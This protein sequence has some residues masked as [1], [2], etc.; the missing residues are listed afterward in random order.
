M[1]SEPTSILAFRNGS[2]G[3]TLAA[4]PALRA[5]RER[6]PQATLSVVVDSIGEDLLKPCPWIDHLIC[7]DKRG[8][9]RRIVA[10]LRL[11]RRLRSLKPSH[12]V[13]FKRFFRNGLLSYLSGARE[14]VGFR[15]EGK[16]PFLTRTIP[17]EQ[18]VHIVDLNLRLAGLLGATS[19]NRSMELFLTPEDR[20]QAKVAAGAGPYIVAHYGGTTTAPDYFPAAHFGGLLKRLVSE[21]ERVLFVGTGPAELKRA[22]DL[23]SVLDN[24][25]AAMNLPVRVTAALI[26]SAALFVGFNSGPAHLAAAVGTPEVVFFRRNQDSEHELRKWAPVSP[27]ARAFVPPM[28]SDDPAWPEF[29][30][31]VVR[32]ARM[33]TATYE[34]E[35]A[36]HV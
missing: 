23:S 25:G 5:L 2:I 29:L 13:L 36:S 4:I 22:S 10:Q 33:L 6:F 8:R 12:A 1:T 14:R 34:D 16:A 17:Y 11:I 31:T 30:D 27:L 19:T 32:E 15:T 24:S 28:A 9:D 35:H 21:G 7:Y 20:A 26:E 3:N 18:D